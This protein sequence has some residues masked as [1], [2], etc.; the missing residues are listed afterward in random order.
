MEKSDQSQP[1]SAELPSLIESGKAKS[2]KTS[3]EP[4]TIK[5][6]VT[7]I[8]FRNE[9]SGYTVF[10]IK[11]PDTEAPLTV[12][13]Y[14]GRIEPEFEVVAQGT[15]T[16]HARFGHQFAAR[17]VSASPPSTQIGMERYLSSGYIK[18]IGPDLAKR[19][20]EHLG[21][22]A[23]D[24]IKEDPRILTDIPGIGAQKA[25]ALVEA[26]SDQSI[27]EQI[28]QF[29][30]EH[31]VSPSFAERIYKRYGDRT[32]DIVQRN[33]YR[34][35]H[36]IRG[37]G[38]KTADTIAI[39]GLN[40]S[41]D[42]PDRLRAGLAFT[43]EK[44]AE[45]GHCF[46]PESELLDKACQLLQVTNRELFFPLLKSA[47]E[48]RDLIRE[49]RGYYLPAAWE[50]EQKIAEFVSSRK[51]ELLSRQN[52]PL[53]V[54][55]TIASVQSGMGL[56]F[57][58]EQKEAVCLASTQRLLVITGG[59]GCGKTTTIRAISALFQEAGKRLMMAAPTGRAAQRMSQVC[60]IPAMTIH[61]L[62][63]YNPGTGDFIHNEQD[64]LPADAVIVD[65]CSM[66]DIYL[67]ASL[68]AA[69][70]NDCT[71]VLVGDKDQLP[72]VGPGKVFGDII[73]SG[74]ASVIRLTHLYRRSAES[75]INDIAI[76]INAGITPSIP[77]PEQHQNA[78]ACFISRS[79]PDEATA[80]IR[81]YVSRE[82]PKNHNFDPSEIM[83]LTPSNKGP[84]GTIALNQALQYSL[85]PPKPGVPELQVG[86][87]TF[88]V[89][90]RVCQ[91]SNNYM[92]DP[93]G[94]FNGDLGIITEI[95]PQTKSLAVVLWDGRRILYKPTDIP[96]LGLAYSLTVHRSQ[97]SEIPCVVLALHDSH[98]MLLERQ[99]LYTAVTR[100]KRSLIII[101]SRRA[102]HLAVSRISSRRRNTAIVEIL[103]G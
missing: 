75:T 22:R 12:T 29:L 7:R 8:T 46:L 26:F 66:L 9:Q 58:P 32:I 100:A 50:A 33:P 11:M 6:R 45:E 15:F 92:I 81:D 103:G 64:P 63:R 56:T 87:V 39:S 65:E 16:K 96:Q 17:S 61:R 5:G 42:H 49:P 99:L 77:S 97:G 76:S 79:D 47:I 102:L 14:I 53:S 95:H 36:D 35:A 19:I 40:M 83:V 24:I 23:L 68:F 27:L 60:D 54:E 57:S 48:D 101:G 13:G 2:D 93:Q 70:P 89:G 10:Q 74:A 80:M 78:D 3:H 62:L 73:D 34:L 69:I 55:Q 88:R 38:F 43:L 20:V 44:G 94:V 30:I 91:R 28:L 90:D 71:L 1:H 21:E 25:K 85:N 84:L 51:K 59:P 98:Y 72:S 52:D 82:L 86:G 4:R 37:I 31:G 18:G 67:A 41:P